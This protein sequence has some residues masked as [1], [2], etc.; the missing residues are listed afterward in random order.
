MK[1][2]VNLNNLKPNYNKSTHNA[3][4]FFKVYKK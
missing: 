1:L 3:K 2:K 4:T